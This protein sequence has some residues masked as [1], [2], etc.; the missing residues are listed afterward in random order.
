MNDTITQNQNNAPGAGEPAQPA[1]KPH[2]F[3]VAKLIVIAAITAFTYMLPSIIP[4]EFP[5]SPNQNITMAIFVAAALLWIL[6][7]MPVYATSV[8][9]IGALCIFASDGAVTPI[10]EYLKAADPD[11]M[12]NYETILN[13]FSSPVIILFL[14]GFGLAA[15]AT[16]YRLDENLA[17]V[18]LKPFGTKPPLVMLGIMLI[19][20]MFAMFVSNTA[21]TVMML[22]MVAPVF[23]SI[24]DSDKGVKAMVL[25]VPF[26][27]NIGGIATPVGTPPNAIA[28]SFLHGANSISFMSWM[29][30]ALPVAVVCLFLIWIV[31]RLFYPFTTKEIRLKMTPHFGKDWRSIFVYVIFGATI[32]LWMT[33]KL[34][35]INSY[36]VALL[37]LIAFTCTGILRASDIR[38]LN[39]D[40][41]WLIAG[42]IAIGTALEQTGLASQLANLV[43]YSMFSGIAIAG[44]IGLFGWLLSNFI[45]NTATANLVIPVAMAIL[46][47]EGVSGHV[48]LSQSIMFVALALSCAMSLPISTPPNAL[49]YSTGRVRN[50]DFIEVGGVISVMTLAVCFGALWLL[51]KFQ[52]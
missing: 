20:G 17:A 2:R 4:G 8:A 12:L 27:A 52:G 42:G 31:L 40:V 45:S 29:A 33:E 35:G 18:M 43:N 28:L 15:A 11:H 38:S 46:T 21:T 39:W 1:K 34:H 48:N 13:S 22:A 44:A 25:A 19:T 30:M 47:E 23:A 26:A 3:H 36:I 24:P 41:I 7:P 5:F 37:P 32:L 9:I 49:A 16:K 10:R 14:G 50:K 6:E 51:T